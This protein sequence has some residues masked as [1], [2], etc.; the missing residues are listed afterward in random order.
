MIL[1]RKALNTATSRSS[2][3]VRWADP[4]EMII[5]PGAMGGGPGAMGGGPGPAGVRFVDGARFEPK[6]SMEPAPAED[7]QPAVGKNMRRNSLTNFGK[8]SSGVGGSS[9]KVVGFGSSRLRKS[10]GGE[11]KGGESK[12]GDEEKQS[13]QGHALD[14]LLAEDGSAASPAAADAAATTPAKESTTRSTSPVP[15][16][17]LRIFQWYQTGSSWPLAIERRNLRAA[18][19][20]LGI[21]VSVDTLNDALGRYGDAPERVE[22]AE[23]RTLIDQLRGMDEVLTTFNR[24]DTDGS[25]DIDVS[26]LHL[27]MHLL[28]L[29]DGDTPQAKA[30]L[31]RF[32][33]DGNQKLDLAEF[34][35]LVE[36]VREYKATQFDEVSRVFHKFDRDHNHAIDA[37]ELRSALYALGL[38]SDSERANAILL[39]HDVDSSG[40]LEIAEFRALVAEMRETQVDDPVLRVFLAFDRD[41]SG[42][43]DIR[44]LRAA[45]EH[46]NLPSD[47]VQ[48]ADTLARYDTDRSGALELGEFRVLCAQLAVFQKHAERQAQHEMMDGVPV[49]AS[50]P[51][52]PSSSSSASDDIARIFHAF[53]A[54]RSGDIDVYE[55]HRALNSLG[56]EASTAHAQR[57]LDK[58]DTDRSQKLE[59]PEFRALVADLREFQSQASEEV[60][61]ILKAFN[62][63]ET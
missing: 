15:D 22:L 46:L 4:D 38:A 48:A 28:G 21:D 14:G 32:D 52:R 19:L 11:S 45:L 41:K 59:L 43:M 8:S 51:P 2:A 18:H 24:I 25:N 55:L 6:G 49:Q 34:R 37:A 7:D 44:E 40:R 36:E 33:E 3:Q 12:G 53:D 54:D 39:K 31:A 62:V 16:E 27:G 9:K 58:Y 61:K 13:Q 42:A 56:L 1:K 29:H 5:L 17:L 35:A 23:F 26:E 20:A 60:E 10:K 63:A 30:L 57:T 47:N 50:G